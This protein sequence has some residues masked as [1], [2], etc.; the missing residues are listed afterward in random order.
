MES[1]NQ[2]TLK[3][4]AVIVAHPDD[5]TLWAGGLLLRHPEW[6][7]FILT[8]N[9]RTDPV[10]AP[11]FHRAL[12]HYRAAGDMGDLLDGGREGALPE[13]LVER[14]ILRLLPSHAY[15]RVLTHSPKGEY[16]EHIMHDEVSDAVSRLFADGALRA[17][18]LWQFAYDDRGGAD[19]PRAAR[20]ADLQLPLPE[21]D[22]REKRRI[23]TDIYE[24]PEQAW[25]TRTTPRVEGFRT[26]PG[27]V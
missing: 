8:M 6:E 10:R 1:A 15:D 22:W 14:T 23:I 18:E 19:L 16:T 11:R 12:A 13:G 7:V 9:H 25:E 3:R 20:D 17:P 27:N 5:E 21:A 26:L 4:V 24:F 2:E